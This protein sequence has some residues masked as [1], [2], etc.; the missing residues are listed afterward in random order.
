MNICILG[1]GPGPFHKFNT[2]EGQRMSDLLTDYAMA[3]LRELGIYTGDEDDE[4][5]E[6]EEEEGEEGEEEGG[7]EEA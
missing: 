1:T 3:L 5:E 6:E 4:E 7:E 2:L